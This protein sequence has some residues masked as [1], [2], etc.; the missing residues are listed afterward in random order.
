[1]QKL[2][3]ILS[4]SLLVFFFGT[5]NLSY[6]ATIIPNESQVILSTDPIHPYIHSL[7]SDTPTYNVLL[8]DKNSNNITDKVKK[9]LQK[10]YENR[11][12]EAISKYLIA[13][14]IEFASE[15]PTRISLQSTKTVSFRH[16]ES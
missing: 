15:N 6:A 8:R 2:I 9:D 10:V 3:R 12:S 7:F 5:N 11:D 14:N 1:M 4:V 16:Q 13:N